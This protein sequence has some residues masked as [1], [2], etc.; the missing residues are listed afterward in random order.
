MVAHYVFFNKRCVLFNFEKSE[1]VLEKYTALKK[2]EKRMLFASG[3]VGN[4]VYFEFT[5]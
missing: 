2:N 3:V 1:S 4:E 5:S